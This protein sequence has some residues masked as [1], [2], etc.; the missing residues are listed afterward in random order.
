VV[1]AILLLAFVIIVAIVVIWGLRYV[2]LLRDGELA[3]GGVTAQQLVWQRRT[4]WIRTDYEFTTAT[5]ELISACCE[6]LSNAVFEIIIPVFY[7]P[8]NPAKHIGAC[9]RYL[10]IALNP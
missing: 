4:S 10:E 9:A 5:G 6:D 1:L 8:H 7:D 3:L 2:P